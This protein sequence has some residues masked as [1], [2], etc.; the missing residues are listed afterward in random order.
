[1]KSFQNHLNYR[2]VENPLVNSREEL[3][4][5]IQSQEK[6]LNHPMI[7]TKRQKRKLNQER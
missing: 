5:V 4:E 7:R 2:Q 1:M 3:I 6:I